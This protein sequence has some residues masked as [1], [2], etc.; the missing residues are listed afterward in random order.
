MPTRRAGTSFCA[1]LISLLV[2]ACSEDELPDPL[3]A[4]LDEEADITK[5][6]P[7]VA[8]SIKR[9]EEGRI[10]SVD[11]SEQSIGDEGLTKLPKLTN[12]HTLDLHGTAV[13]DAGV[14]HVAR[15]KTL[16]RLFLWQTAVGETGLHALQKLENLEVIVVPE[17]IS[18]ETR[19]AFES[20]NSDCRV[21]TLDEYAE[22]SPE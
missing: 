8:N 13:T 10:V 1:F 7:L 12:L 14:K 15:V 18:R 19:K 20:E 6:L 17:S 11:L 21:V 22:F 16:K 2:I 9:D 4:A 5:A 3:T